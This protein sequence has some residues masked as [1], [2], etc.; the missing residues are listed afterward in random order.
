M[1]ENRRYL[2]RGA[3][4]GQ[5]V[6]LIGL[7]LLVVAMSG[8]AAWAFM[9]YQQQKTNVDS[10][11][12]LAVAAAKK[13][14]ADSDEVKFAQREKEP[15][16]EFAGPNDYGHLTFKYPKTWSVYVASDMTTGGGKYTAYL[17]PIVVPP[18]TGSSSQQQYALRVTIEQTAYDVV[19]DSYKALI[20]KG[21]LSS[22][23]ITTNGHDGTRLDGKF[24]KDLRGA[25]VLFKIR[26]KTATIQ[27]D[28][29]TFKPDF[30]NIIKTID[31]NS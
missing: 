11:I 8:T 29:D 10:K 24:T 12:A 27:T 16:R 19:L 4:D 25:A 7:V 14:Q 17:N 22:Q 9:N 13:T 21:D 18:I 15:N 31:F 3:V 23:P 2:A 5:L 26:D 1:I 20:K 6:A 30:E 28:A